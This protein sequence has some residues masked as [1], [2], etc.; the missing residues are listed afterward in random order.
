M[1]KY[2]LIEENENTVSYNYF[3]QG[4]E[5]FGTI[6]MHKKTAEIVTAEVAK[7]D[8]FKQYFYHMIEEIE[9]FIEKNNF[10]KDGYVAWY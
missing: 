9:K 3:P 4:H 5:D 2:K 8:K 6:T 1:V 10:L 7:T